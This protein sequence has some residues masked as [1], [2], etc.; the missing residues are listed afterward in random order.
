ML[1]YDSPLCKALKLTLDLQPSMFPTEARDAGDEGR[2]KPRVR[3][4]GPVDLVEPPA[5]TKNATKNTRSQ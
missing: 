5:E 2:R 1:A 3:R 4:D